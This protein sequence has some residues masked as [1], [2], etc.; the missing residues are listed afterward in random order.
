MPDAALRRAASVLDDDVLRGLRAQHIR[1]AACCDAA[2]HLAV[3]AATL[4]RA[5]ASSAPDIFD[6][7]LSSPLCLADTRVL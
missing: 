2:A 3:P 7:C 4:G 5:E 6:A 1:A